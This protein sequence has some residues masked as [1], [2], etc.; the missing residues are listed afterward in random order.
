MQQI[1]TPTDC[2][3]LRRD[4][5]SVSKVFIEILKIPKFFKACYR[6][7]EST[8][9]SV[10]PQLKKEGTLSS[11]A[12]LKSQNLG[13]TFSQCVIGFIGCVSALL[14]ELKRCNALEQTFQMEEAPIMLEIA[15]KKWF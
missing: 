1:G 2:P 12:D 5:D 8:K 9:N 15:I 6:A 7:C 14:L 10:L 4:L 3:Q 13:N 11:K